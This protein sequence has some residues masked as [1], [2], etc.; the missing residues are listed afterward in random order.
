MPFYSIGRAADSTR[1]FF[2]ISPLFWHTQNSNTTRNILFPIFWNK[3]QGSFAFN[4][5]KTVLFPLYWHY[6]DENE[7]NNVLFPLIWSY[8]SPS[9]KSF[10]L[11][12]LVAWGK[13]PI[14]QRGYFALTP[15]WLEQKMCCF[16]FSFTHR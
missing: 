8:R 12:P 15:L 5:H 14:S 13:S 1:S 7:N 3:T 4:T 9:Y 10:A 16:L 11:F 2:S 6:R